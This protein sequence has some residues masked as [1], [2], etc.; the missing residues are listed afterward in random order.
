MVYPALLT[1]MRTPR[2]PVVDWTDALR[3]FKWTRPFRRKT[4]SGFCACVIT[5]QLASS[6][7]GPPK[8]LY[9]GNASAILK[10][11]VTQAITSD[12][13]PTVWRP[14][15][16]EKWTMSRTINCPE[17]SAIRPVRR[18]DGPNA[19]TRQNPFKPILI[20]IQQDAAVCRY[21][22]TANIL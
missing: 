1:L 13:L 9:S 18:S 7:S 14:D 6:Y 5:L 3:R 19:N 2:L 22:F 21:L 11:R 10:V 8:G 17:S 20:K 16:N 15:Q 4:K 12:F